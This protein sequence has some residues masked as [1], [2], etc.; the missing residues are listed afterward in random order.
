MINQLEMDALGLSMNVKFMRQDLQL[1]LP[2]T[3]PTLDSDS[4]QLDLAEQS[5][6]FDQLESPIDHIQ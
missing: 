2:L 5:N 4:V 3:E 1:S 6:Q